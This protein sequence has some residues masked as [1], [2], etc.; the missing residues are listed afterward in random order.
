MMQI[1]SGKAITTEKVTC[2][3]YGTPGMGKT[4]LLGTLPGK[5]LI[6]DIDR[7]TSVLA[8]CENVDIVRISEDLH[9]LQEIVSALR[10]KCEYQN[11]ALD[12]V[13]EFERAM[14]AMYGRKG[15]NNGV[16][17]QASYLRTD[18]KII[19]WCRLFR[20][21]PCNVIFTAWETQKEVIAT[22]GEKY[23]QARPMIR[24]DNSEN[25]CGLCDIVGRLM[26]NP[27]DGTRYV[28]LDGS[29]TIVAKDRLF[30]RKFCKFEE[31]MNVPTNLE[32]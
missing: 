7:G 27:Q 5:T 9:E 20:T 1:I 21:L 17:D 24:K 10:T 13:S 28:C 11:V 16:P 25:L 30:K 23:T 8:G 29:Q 31:L 22:T 4:T 26:I 15:N 18:Y 12:S 14:L 32:K 3:I 19:D 2:L 6:I